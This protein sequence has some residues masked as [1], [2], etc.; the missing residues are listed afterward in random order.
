MRTLGTEPAGTALVERY[1]ALREDAVGDD[2]HGQAVRGLALLRHR[3]MAAWMRSL[4]DEARSAEQPR[5]A[6]STSKL[7]VPAAIEQPLIAIL[8]TMVLTTALEE[9]A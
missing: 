1:E 8:A 3:G 9:L 5:A 7:R 2:G 6:G 4:G